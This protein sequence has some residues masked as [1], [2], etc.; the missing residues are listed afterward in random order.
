MSRRNSI[1]RETSFCSARATTRR[2]SGG[3]NSIPPGSLLSGSA[4]GTRRT[5]GV[6]LNP[7]GCQEIEN[8][9]DA[10]GKFRF[11]EE[12]EGADRALRFAARLRRGDLSGGPAPARSMALARCSRILSLGGNPGEAEKCLDAAKSLGDCGETA[13]ADALFPLGGDGAESAVEAL[14]AIA[15]PEARSAALEMIFRDRGPSPAVGWMKTAGLDATDLNP[16]GRYFLLKC[17]LELGRWAQARALLDALGDESPLENPALCR[18]AAVTR[19]LS[20]VPDELRPLLRRWPPFY[21]DE[22]HLLSG[23][24][25]LG[26]REK[27]RGLFALAEGS[28]RGAGCFAA[29][30]ECEQYRLWLELS[31]PGR[32]GAGRFGERFRSPGAAFHLVPLGLRFGIA[33]DPGA[34]E[35]E[36]LRYA[37]LHGRI[38]RDAACARLALVVSG[39]GAPL[40]LALLRERAAECLGTLAGEGLSAPEREELESL[41]ADALEDDRMA[42]S[43]EERFGEAGFLGAHELADELEAR[44]EWEVLCEYCEILFERTRSLR[45]A[46]RLAVALHRAKKTARLVGFVRENGDLAEASAAVRDLYL[47]ALYSE[48]ELLCLR[49]ELEE[50]P[51]PGRDAR[52]RADLAVSLC[53]WDALYAAS[54]GPYMEKASGCACGLADLAGFAARLGLRGAG[55]LAAS[56]AR[57]LSV[58]RAVAERAG[59]EGGG[60][61]GR[62]LEKTVSL[63]FGGSARPGTPADRD[64]LELDVRSRLRRAEVPLYPAARFLG[65]SLF[66]LMFF[67]ATENL[68][69][70]DVPT[71][72]A[73][74]SGGAEGEPPRLDGAGIAGFDCTA[75]VTLGFLGLVEEAL[76]AFATARVTHLTPAW[77]FEEKRS[78][79]F[80]CRELA[81]DARE[82]DRLLASGA[83]EKLERVGGPDGDLSSRVGP[84]LAALIAEAEKRD[85]GVPGLVVR[86][87]PVRE[88][89]SLMGEEADIGE[90][91]GVVVGCRRVVEK[92]REKGLLT[93]E[94]EEKI[95]ACREFRESPGPEEPGVPDGARLYLDASAVMPFLRAGILGELKPSGFRVFVSPATVS[96]TETLLRYEESFAEISDCMERVR[97]AL[98]SRIVSGG[99]KVAAA[100]GE[101]VAGRGALY[102]N[103]VAALRALAGEC[104]L[105]VT[106]DGFF[107]GPAGADGLPA[108]VL[109]TP[110]VLDALVSLGRITPGRRLE[111][112]DRLRGAGHFIS[113]EETGD[114]GKSR[115]PD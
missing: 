101:G 97:S 36:I 10:L 67:S 37:A 77:L 18:L 102:G 63:S 43:L 16:G 34:V 1:L 60:D 8:G 26:D 61:L 17:Q 113:P 82:V 78:A 64:R 57:T 15:S 105:I 3:T 51:D 56:A 66:D 33:L 92:L 50:N 88:V 29:A 58:A 21:S 84:E 40:S 4:S 9:A 93:A 52:L 76:D 114:R 30:K 74:P 80:R 46:E 11:F 6:F 81:K 35:G 109:S 86:S 62:E 87:A 47:R 55:E 7:P 96:E 72:R 42:G 69:R 111:C 49:R 59:W 89:D 28:L 108:R 20:A 99:V 65:E 112:R 27:A 5:D 31:A 19:T 44:G 91:A 71:G 38:F 12:F 70:S 98:R 54:R 104:D 45:S 53:D 68:S 41:V 48:G 32:S 79:S 100:V 110:D 23:A 106:D 107:S 94:A 83:L 2:R 25:A 14:S 13:I 115:D 103:T 24:S 22:F 85:D 73:V 75:L 39:E 95:A 90:R